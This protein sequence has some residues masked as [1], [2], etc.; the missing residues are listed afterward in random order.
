MENDLHRMPPCHFVY[1]GQLCFKTDYKNGDGKLEAYNSAG[2]FFC[3]PDDT[4]VQPV[5]QEWETGE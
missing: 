3:T 5:I 2:E 1:E 4:I